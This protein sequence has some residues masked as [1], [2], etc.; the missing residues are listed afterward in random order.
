MMNTGATM[1]I[2]D[3][4]R[5]MKFVVR[6]GDQ[7]LSTG[8]VRRSVAGRDQVV[9]VHHTLSGER[10]TA[11]MVYYGVRREFLPERTAEIL[12]INGITEAELIALCDT[13]EG[14]RKML[15]VSLP[16]IVW[17][18]TGGYWKETPFNPDNF[19]SI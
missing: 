5:G 15:I 12:K 3:V 10:R 6:K 1:Q 8:K 16:S 14:S 7:I 17:A 13:S 11:S 2:N 4:K 9:T 19:V 18:G